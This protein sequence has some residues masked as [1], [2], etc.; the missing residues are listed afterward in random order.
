M[1]TMLTARVYKKLLSRSWTL[2]TDSHFYSPLRKTAALR[3]TI[4]FRGAKD[5]VY[6]MAANHIIKWHRQQP[7]S[8]RARRPPKSGELR[9]R[10]T[11][12]GPGDRRRHGVKIW[13]TRRAETCIKGQASLA[14][15]HMFTQGC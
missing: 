15:R 13:V 8:A 1:A 10:D 7:V 11:R 2:Q 4:R 12:T 9:K 3:T 5:S 14:T 6:F